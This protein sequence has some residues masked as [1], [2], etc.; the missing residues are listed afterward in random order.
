MALADER[1]VEID[2]A[3]LTAT[4]QKPIWKQIGYSLG[5]GTIHAVVGE[6]GSGKSTLALALFGILPTGFI[7]DYNTFSVCGTDLRKRTETNNRELFL[8]PQNPNLAFHPYR[9]IGSQMLD[10]L[11][12]SGNQNG[13]EN[14]LKIWESMGLSASQWDLYPKALSGGEKQRVCLSLAFLSKPK[15]LILDEPT[16]GLDAAS[17]N[18]VLKIVQNM[19]N[20]GVGVVFIT[21]ELRIV[22]SMASQV[23]IMKQGEVVETSKLQHKRLEPKSDYGKALTE[24]YRLFV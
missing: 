9:T 15:I 1:L 20:L 12:I 2:S 5:A 13:K 11:K 16:T 8:V 17:E 4:G 6:S 22:E 10:F 7:L 21:H 3:S 23:T 14:L 18:I 24:S 19:A